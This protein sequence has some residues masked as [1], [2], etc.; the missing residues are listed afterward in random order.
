MKRL[1]C[2]LTVL[3]GTL[4]IMPGQAVAQNHSIL[5]VGGAQ[6]K[7]QVGQKA[8]QAAVFKVVDHRG[9]PV[10]TTVDFAVIKGSGSLSASKVQTGDDGI[11]RVAYTAGFDPGRVEVRARA[12]QLGG[13]HRIIDF[14]VTL[15]DPHRKPPAPVKK[16]EAKPEKSGDASLIRET[17]VK[18]PA[19]VKPAPVEKPV[20]PSGKAP[21]I[22]I[23]FAG[24][25]MTVEPGQLG[26]SKLEV[27]VMDNEGNVL[28]GVKVNFRLIQGKAQLMPDSAVTDSK[29]I[30]GVSIR[31]GEDEGPVQVKATTVGNDDLST[32]F[33]INVVAGKPEVAS[34][35][36]PRPTTSPREITPQPVFTPEP[37]PQPTPDY[38]DIKIPVSKPRPHGQYMR[39]PKKV[40]VVGG[41]YQSASPGARLPAPLVV[42]VTDE[43][44]NP[45][46]ATVQFTIIGGDAQVTNRQVRT[47][48]R[49]LASTF[50]IVNSPNPIRIV[51]EVMES[52]GLSTIAYANTPRPGSSDGANPLI[53]SSLP[54]NQP[55]YPAA[56][57]FYSMRSQNTDAIEKT[58]VVQLEIG[59]TD[60]RNQPVATPVRFSVV[61]GNVA[62]L[63]PVVQTNSQGRGICYVDLGSS[64]GIFTVEA[65]SLEN[66]DLKAVFRSGPQIRSGPATEVVRPG[67]R[68]DNT[69]TTEKDFSVPPPAG[70]N[71]GGTPA[72]IAVLSGGGQSGKVGTRLPEPLEILVTDS[73]GLPVADTMVSF[74]VQQGQARLEKN[75]GRT[76]SSGKVTNF[77][78][79]GNRPGMVEIGIRLRDNRNLRTTIQLN[80]EG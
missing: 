11:V 7:V 8:R 55:D 19:P 10:K 74:V 69:A 71:T 77:V 6:Q 50:V 76:D 65:Q 70:T 37:T 75:I 67:I 78:T 52:P 9:N 14:T 56:I 62:V 73:R 45:T 15:D 31:A 68:P 40:T 23:G 16:P 4:W 27:Q 29:G 32:I 51:A 54:T 61:N 36:R 13:I 58:G 20:T 2:L 49:G 3:L 1:F 34:T 60:F 48:Q 44:N 59:V 72:L 43:D 18:K 41:D 47:D 66:P 12:S 35:P 22:V 42:Y 5:V 80:A 24:S 25:G 38:G 33:N 64:M 28:P 39:D 17:P 79:L 53:K 46:E 63:N 30:A 26:R 57:A 21:S